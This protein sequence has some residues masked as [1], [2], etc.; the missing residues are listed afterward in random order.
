MFL[1]TTVFTAVNV[2]RFVEAFAL[3]EAPLNTPVL[4]FKDFKRWENYTY[5]VC[6]SVLIWTADILVI[7]RCYVIWE[8]NRWIVAVPIVLL[9]VSVALNVINI[10]WFQQPWL[11]FPT[12]KPI[13]DFVYPGHLAQ[14]VLTTALIAYKMW[15]Q[16]R[17]SEASGLR[18]AFNVTLLSVARII[19][20][21]ALIYTL[22]LTT[23][24]VLYFMQ[25]PAMVILQAAIVPSIGIV[26]VLMFIR[27]HMAVLDRR[28]L[29]NVSSVVLP[30]WIVET[31]I[32]DPEEQGGTSFEGLVRQ[33]I[34]YIERTS[35]VVRGSR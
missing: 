31:E 8:R 5:V 11:P 1:L 17:I 22:Q 28:R 2:Y 35:K 33:E 13:L 3:V 30:A 23:L 26:F 34:D 19:V 20:E 10:Y 24:V 29:P 32:K 6:S 9:L 15:Q 27:V 4:F 16:H 14:N 18:P 12:I 21:S 7:Y 25:H